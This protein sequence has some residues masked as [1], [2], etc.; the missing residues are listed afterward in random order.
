[1]GRR[2]EGRGTSGEE[3]R[4]VK[5]FFSQEAPGKPGKDAKQAIEIVPFESE[6]LA[7]VWEM[8]WSR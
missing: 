7:V 8:D 5:A 4:A 6:M 1:M 2:G 3:G